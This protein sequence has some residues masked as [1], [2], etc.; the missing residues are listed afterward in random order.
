MMLRQFSTR[1]VFVPLVRGFT[2]MEPEWPSGRRITWSSTPLQSGAGPGG[3]W[4]VLDSSSCLP[5]GPQPGPYTAFLDERRLRVTYQGDDGQLRS[6]G[7]TGERLDRPRR[8]AAP[9]ARLRVPWDDFTGHLHV[10]GT[11]L[12]DF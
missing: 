9:C 7:Y 3:G 12:P 8:A 5:S 2:E 11:G 6:R 1:R 4:T 10:L